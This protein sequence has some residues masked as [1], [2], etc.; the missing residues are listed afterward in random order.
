LPSWFS[1]FI[2][3]TLLEPQQLV[4]F[5][6]V[7]LL[8]SLIVSLGGLY[9]GW[10]VYKDVREAGFDPLVKP[11]GFVH[12]ILQHKYY[13]DELYDFLFV[14]PAFW[15]AETFTYQWLD[16]GVIDGFLHAVSRVAF[17]LGSIFRN[18]IDK[19]I[20]NGFG[21]FVGESVKRLGRYF[22]FIQTGRVQQYLVMALVIAL[23]TFFYYLLF[24]VRP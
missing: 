23:G 11:L 5:H 1:H 14:R 20:V 2:Q 10:F 4:T 3:S 19:P 24:Q 22:R 18:F 21:D 13:F 9:S 15:L 12:T 17:S 6:P 8:T 7:P 16:R